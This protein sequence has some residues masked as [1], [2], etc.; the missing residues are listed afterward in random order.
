[1]S[2]YLSLCKAQL[3]GFTR[4][5]SMLFFTILFPVMFMVIFNG[6]YGGQEESTPSVLA[7]GDVSVLD[8]ADEDEFSIS[9]VDSLDQARELLAD[10]DAHAAVEQTG[11]DLTIYYSE[12]NP[13]AAQAAIGSLEALVN[14]S[15]IAQLSAAAPDIEMVSPQTIPVEDETL[16]PVQFLTPGLLAWAIAISG[17]FGA[18]GTIVD[19]KRTKLLRRL[20]LSPAP[21]TTV[22]GARISVSLMIGLLQLAIFLI[23]ATVF[24]GL[25]LPTWWWVSIP[26][27]VLA[28]ISFLA[29]GVVVGSI[30]ETGP[31]AAGLS[32]LI[33]M[34][35]AFASGAFFPL[36]LSPDWLATLSLLSPMRYLNEGLQKV[37]VQGE[38]PLS[39]GPQVGML[40]LFTVVIT[41]IGVKLFKWEQ[42]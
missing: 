33:V 15:N 28:N 7:I 35:M 24:Y 16:S 4:D 1:M 10:G 21:V 27:V 20:R 6:F 40:L 42:V 9:Q 30:A 17:V 3:R 19:W 31:G 12:A 26:L 13:I 32:N 39:L 34:P 23:M 36:S 25:H 22:M 11:E 5:R 14:A 41:A 18:A 29:I 8:Q 38:S 37:M 2:S